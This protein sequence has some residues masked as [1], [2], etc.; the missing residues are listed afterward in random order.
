M[1]LPFAEVGS[2][3]GQDAL[4][5]VSGVYLGVNHM[6]VAEKDSDEIVDM[7]GKALKAGL[8]AHET[9]DVYKQELPSGV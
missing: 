5:Q 2:S 8:V 4:G 1:D 7:S 9:M 6:A 3:H